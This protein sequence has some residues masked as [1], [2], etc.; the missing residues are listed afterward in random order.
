[1][2]KL[3]AADVATT[4]LIIM[5]RKKTQASKYKQEKQ[6]LYIFQQKTQQ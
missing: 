1:M 3:F 2:L 4:M 5:K 6:N